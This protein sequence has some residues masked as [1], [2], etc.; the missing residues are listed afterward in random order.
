[1]GDGA[2]AFH[3]LHGHKSKNEMKVGHADEAAALGRTPINAPY[4]IFLHHRPLARLQF[5]HTVTFP[6]HRPIELL[7][8]TVGIFFRGAA[9]TEED[10]I[11]GAVQ[12]AEELGHLGRAPIAITG[13]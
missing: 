13:V 6:R 11:Y 3:C 4:V 2:M 8:F 9:M 10:S 12:T 5:S 7:F 1:M